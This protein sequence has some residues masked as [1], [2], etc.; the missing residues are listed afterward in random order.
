[1]NIDLYVEKVNFIN[2]VIDIVVSNAFVRS[3]IHKLER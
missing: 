3:E 2:L 1:M